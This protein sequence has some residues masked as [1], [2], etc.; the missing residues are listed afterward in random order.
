MYTA[1]AL[2]RRFEESTPL[3][4][5][6]LVQFRKDPNADLTDLGRWLTLVGNQPESR[7][8]HLVPAVMVFLDDTR[9]L[10]RRGAVGGKSLSA[11]VGDHAITI[12]HRMT[13][14]KWAAGLPK[15]T[16]YYGVLPFKSDAM[17]KQYVEAFRTW[18]RE[19]RAEFGP[20]PTTHPV[21]K[22]K[23]QQ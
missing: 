21:P 4:V 7:H 17:R 20:N 22:P 11:R 2:L 23:V 10:E 12:L 9:T 15:I 16:M 5:R 19:H 6:W 14:K 18:Y 8:R 3:L 13:G 1:H